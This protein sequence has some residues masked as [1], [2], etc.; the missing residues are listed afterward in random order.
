MPALHLHSAFAFTSDRQ[1]TPPIPL[2][3]GRVLAV[4]DL[5]VD[6]AENMAWCKAIDGEAH[7][8]A[9]ACPCLPVAVAR[10]PPRPA[11]LFF[12]ACAATQLPL[13]IPLPIT[14]QA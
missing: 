4:T 14:L 6:Y 5:H 1:S 11:E 7:R 8:Q 10:D 3:A 2:A 12:Q 13:P 9:P